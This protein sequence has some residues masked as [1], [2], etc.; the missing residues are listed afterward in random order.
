MEPKDLQKAGIDATMETWTLL[1]KPSLTDEE[2]DQMI[3]TAYASHYLWEKSRLG[4]NIHQARAH[5]LISRVMCVA[6]QP[7][8]AE[9]H[10]LRCAEF[11]AQAD[12]RKDFDDVYAIEASARAAAANNNAAKA[13][14]LRAKAAAMAKEVADQED[15]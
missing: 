7:A 3:A 10:A 12:D 6:G 11:T 14:E 4:T 2:R 5:W 1:Q 13:K 15:R 8:L 9:R